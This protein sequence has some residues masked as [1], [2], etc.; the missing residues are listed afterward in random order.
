MKK[1]I[2]IAIAILLGSTLIGSITA[3]GV[4]GARDT[5]KDTSTLLV[6]GIGMVKAKPDK[7][8]VDLTITT[9]EK[10]A[11]DAQQNNDKKANAVID[12]I[13]KMG[14]K[15]E[16]IITT[17]YWL[18]PVY[19]WNPETNE[20]IL[21]GYQASYSLNVTATDLKKISEVIDTATSNGVNQI[22]GIS[23]DIANKEEFQNEALKLAMRD[24]KKKAEIALGEYGKTIFAINTITLN[25]NQMPMPLMNQ[26]QANKSYDN[27]QGGVAPDI[28]SGPLEFTVTVNV[29]FG[30]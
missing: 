19:K 4:A 26:M 24:A 11:R 28:M 1:T 3:F 6:T 23:F 22:G 2:I 27:A 20:N 29:E 16:Q 21:N 9:I 15:E 10:L 13:K 12:A 30:Y 17:G 5:G 14:I 7:Y 18:N 25:S 8:R